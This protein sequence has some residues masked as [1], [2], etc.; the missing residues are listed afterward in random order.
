MPPRIG[1]FMAL[2]PDI[3]LRIHASAEPVDFFRTDTDVEIRYGNSDWAGLVVTPLM[4]DALTPLCAPELH[5]RIAHRPAAERLLDTP[6]IVFERAPIDWAGWFKAKS[7]PVSHFR[8]PR[9]DRGY[10]ALQAAAQSLGVALESVTFA[11]DHIARGGACPGL[12]GRERGCGY[13][14]AYAGLPANIPQH[15]QN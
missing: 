1:R 12:R 3:D 5:A 9:F 4:E 11:A 15:P 6:L 2:H 7:L 10:L 14:S 13:R 8:G